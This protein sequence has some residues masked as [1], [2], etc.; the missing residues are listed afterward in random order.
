MSLLAK[1]GGWRAAWAVLAFGGRSEP[2][3]QIA[4][5]PTGKLMLQLPQSLAWLRDAPE[6]LVVVIDR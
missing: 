6:P 5:L 1:A 2:D 4:D 3:W